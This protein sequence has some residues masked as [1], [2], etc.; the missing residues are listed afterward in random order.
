[1]DSTSRHELMDAYA[2]VPLITY[3]KSSTHNN[4]E[5]TCWIID[6]FQQ[7]ILVKFSHTTNNKAMKWTS[8][9]PLVGVGNTCFEPEV[10]LREGPATVNLK[11][12]VGL[13]IQAEAAYFM[14]HIVIATVGK[15]RNVR[16]ID[17]IASHKW[18]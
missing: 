13:I 6:H 5:D 1:M 12:N 15:H 14:T 3:N 18:Y 7:N 16:G 9:Q 2:N 8:A 4:N 10:I 17:T 11:T